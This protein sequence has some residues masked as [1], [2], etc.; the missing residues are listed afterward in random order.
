MPACYILTSR[1]TGYFYIGS[2]SRTRV[3]LDDHKY[4]LSRGIHENKKL[5]LV[6]VGW[7]DIIVDLVETDTIEEA[8]NIEHSLLVKHVGSP[9]CCNLATNPH[10]PT[11]GVITD[12]MRRSSV[13]KAIAA[14]I[15]RK[16]TDEHRTNM[17]IAHK[18]MTQSQETKSRISL[19]KS[20]QVEIDG[21]IYLSARHAAEE[22]KVP[23]ETIRSRLKSEKKGYRYITK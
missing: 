4:R 6:F 7:D 19:T 13:I 16:Y 11:Q 2:T 17:S 1:T 21:I 10:D 23:V 5:Q 8:R 9:L 14:N 15:G 22:L 12:D 3:R 18:G 20:R